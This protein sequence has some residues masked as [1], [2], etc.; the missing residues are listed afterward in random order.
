MTTQ[1]TLK[2]LYSEALIAHSRIIEASGRHDS[3]EHQHALEKV[4]QQW[5]ELK[6]TISHRAIFSSNESL[7]DINTSEIKYL[8]VDYQLAELYAEFAKPT[9][10]HNL[11]KSIVCYLHYLTNLS[12]YRLLDEAQQMKYDRIRQSPFEIQALH[13]TAQLR[14]D[15]KIAN[16]KLEKQL[17]AKL[18]QLEKLEND[19]NEYNNTDEELIRELYVDRLK[20]LALKDFDNIRVIAQELEIVQT[21]P[22]SKIVEIH[23]ER[24]KSKDP[25]QFTEKLE[26]INRDMLSKEGKI[27]RPFTLVK[28]DDLKKKVFGTGQYL[29]TMTVEEFLEQELA[30]GGIITGGGND[31]PEESEDEDDLDKADAET[32]KQREW[33]DFTESHAKGSGNTI[34]RG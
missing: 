20:S 7:E 10:A 29:P 12:N 9:R 34:N 31:G 17:A 5:I 30:N 6:T 19:D 22:E 16:Y 25:T 28:R 27:L 33:D 13:E 21:M 26:Y 14:R 8:S 23:D 1:R 18:D 2:Q 4:L 24:T 3:D 32:Y 15:E 11:K